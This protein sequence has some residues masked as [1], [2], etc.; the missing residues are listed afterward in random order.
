MVKLSLLS[1]NLIIIMNELIKNQKLC[2]YLYYK[3]RYPL[4][5]PDIPDTSILLFKNLFPQPF[6]PSEVQTDDSTSLRV[7]YLR[8]DFTREYP[9]GVETQVY[10]DIICA[11]ANWLINSGD[12]VNVGEPK[13]R[14]YEIMSEI[15]ATLDNK[16]IDTVGKLHFVGFNHIGVNKTFDGIRLLAM[17]NTL[18]DR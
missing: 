11:K 9:V 17:M 10:F 4:A 14:P 7:F 3:D 13:V 15:V 6:D 8:G 16:S 18:H 1:P 12:P 5:Q 2:K